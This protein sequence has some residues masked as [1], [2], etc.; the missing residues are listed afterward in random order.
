MDASLVRRVRE[1]ARNRCEY[2]HLPA[3]FS[4][5]PFEIDHVVAAQHGGVTVLSNLAFCCFA[6]NHHKGPN[7]AG[8]D[9][10]KRRKAWLFNPRRHGWERH[11]RWNGAI[12]LGRTAIAR[13]TIAVL[14]INSS[15][16][17][18]QRSALM[19]EGVCF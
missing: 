13:A 19:E 6:D 3:E 17:I 12:L 9:P 14:Q 4:S 2:C 16:R 10:K 7:L 1:R 11:F 15:H 5:I 8:I 18:A